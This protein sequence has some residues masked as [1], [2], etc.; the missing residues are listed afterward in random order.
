VAACPA[1]ARRLVGRDCSPAELVAEV[2][3]EDRFLRGTGG[4]VTFSGGEPLAQP[5]F[6]LACA[7]ALRAAGI[8]TAVETAGF[9]PR[10]LLPE[11]ASFDLVLFDLKHVDRRKFRQVI[12]KG[13]GPILDNLAALLAAGR[14]L[15]L[16]LTLVPGFNDDAADLRAIARWLRRHEP[17]AAP[18]LLQPFH[19]LAVAK[20]GLLGRPYPFA[21]QPPSTRVHLEAAAALLRGEG[22]VLAAG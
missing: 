18:V 15:E 8:H 14:P 12:G 13:P 5:D 11:V 20:A 16:R 3:A 10:R 9:W 2:L 1:R 17:G 21:G 22:V 4:G 7:R 19:R 6:V